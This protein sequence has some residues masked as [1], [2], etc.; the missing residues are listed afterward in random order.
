M[1]DQYLTVTAL[2]KYIKRKLSGDPHLKTVWLRGEISNFKHHSRGHMYLSL[3]DNAARIQAVMFAGNNRD[4]KFNPENGM[5]VLIKG[6]I[7]VYEPMG[8]YQL[9]IKEMQPDGIGALYLAFEQLKEKLEQ[10]GL[11]AIERKK[12][13]PAYPNHI[14]V[15]TSPTGAAVR[16]ILSTI[17]RRYPVVPVSI[18][19]VLVQGE[20]AA[21][22]VANAIQYANQNLDCDVLIVGRGGGSIEDLWGFNEEIVAR[23]IADSSIPVISAVGH[24]TDTTI[25]DFAADLRAAT[26]TGAAELAVPSIVELQENTRSLKHRLIRFM[27]S[28][29]VEDRQKLNRLQR[30]YAFKYPEQLLRQKEQDLDR[31]ME[32][33]AKQMKLIHSQ[34]T[35]KWKNIR[36]RLK[37]QGPGTQINETKERLNKETRQLQL[38][39]QE[40]LHSKKDQFHNNL[41]KLTLLNPLEIMKRGYAIPFKEN[42]NV[43]KEVAH[44]KEGSKLALKVHDGTINCE[45]LD[46]EEDEK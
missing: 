6:E 21:S 13:I 3:K 45:V 32:R 10:E 1:N 35:E 31:I 43:V 25:S 34:Q 38:R 12:N 33:H 26:P 28:K 41:D 46:V 7:N 11:F 20:R 5:N 40:T 14:G 19:P 37:Q 42:G 27:E 24:E 9:Y 22:S 16:D 23:A 29:S 30:S 17:K 36:N 8:Q 18:L 44:V 2:T 15:I 39:F 4:L